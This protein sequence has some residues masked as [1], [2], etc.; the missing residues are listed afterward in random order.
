[1]TRLVIGGMLERKKGVVLSVSSF[2]GVLPSALLAVYS[3]SKAYVDFFMRSLSYEYRT[4]GLVFEAHTPAL[5][6]SGQ[7][8]K[9]GGGVGKKGDISWELDATTVYGCLTLA[10]SVP[11][12]SCANGPSRAA[13][14]AVQ[15][16]RHR[17][18][19]A[20]A[21]EL[22]GG[23]AWPPWPGANLWRPASLRDD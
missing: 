4:K 22:R 16:S 12:R 3:G 15:G 2:A 18:H 8:K 1:M 21:E 14:Q 19:P 7:V 17:L 23:F 6:V 10:R 20:V 13:D 9:G 5:V 11:S